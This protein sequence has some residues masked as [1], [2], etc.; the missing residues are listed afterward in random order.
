MAIA[1]GGI[2]LVGA[3]ALGKLLSSVGAVGGLLGFVGAIYGLLL[4]Y[5]IGFL[6]IPLARYFWI[7]WRNTAIVDRNTQRQQRAEQ[8]SRADAQLQRKLGFAQQFAAETV[9]TDQDLIYSSD[10]DLV[11]QE[12]E[13]MD[14]ID[15]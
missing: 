11:E 5:G 15:D 12:I 2:N 6:A 8:L 9:I 7:Q 14:L 1:L 10:R 4:L 13:K 3:L